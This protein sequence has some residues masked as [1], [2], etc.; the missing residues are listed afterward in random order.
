M[1]VDPCYFYTPA[2]RIDYVLRS[3]TPAAAVQ[4]L[5]LEDSIPQRA[6]AAARECLRTVDLSGTGLP[7]VM[8]RLNSIETPD[9]LADLRTLLELDG[10]IGGVPVLAIL[11][12]K[13]GAGRDVEI[14]RSLLATLANPP[15]I[16]SFIETVDAVEH[17]FDIAAASDALCFGQAD[18]VAEMYAPDESYLAH[19][20]ARLCV[21][22]ARYGL[23]AIDTNSFELWDLAMIAEQSQAA[24]RCG[25]TGKAAIHP[26]QV[27]PIVETFAIDPAELDGYRQT[28]KDYESDANGFAVTKDRVLAPPFVAKSRRMLAL[29]DT[30]P[31]AAAQDRYSGPLR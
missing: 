29:L 14:Y 16:A 22:A 30:G 25:F 4:V 7:G 10:Q 26:K 3:G 18:L 19:A 23:P 24:K 5:D 20:R 6:K 28:I 31:Q 11:A 1:R 21:A 17:A 12:P 27:E 9:G 8:V 13:V 2:L 15:Q